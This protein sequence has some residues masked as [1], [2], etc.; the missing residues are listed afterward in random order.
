[1]RPRSDGVVLKLE[2]SDETARESASRSKQRLQ[3]RK[4]KGVSRDGCMGVSCAAS[5]FITRTEPQI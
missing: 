4:G 3:A 1:M 2:V 5:V